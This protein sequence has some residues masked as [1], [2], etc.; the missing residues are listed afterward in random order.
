MGKNEFKE[1]CD[2][3][4]ESAH[5]LAEAYDDFRRIKHDLELAKATAWADGQV[6]GANADQRKAA[7]YIIVD[8][9]VEKLMDAEKSV[10]TKQI[11][12]K[13]LRNIVEYAIWN[14]VNGS[15]S[16]GGIKELIDASHTR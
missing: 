14:G 15:N 11:H 8:P 5:E 6:I 12:E 1:Y 2:L 9:F 4:R 3:W 7:L 16:F 13:Y 10:M